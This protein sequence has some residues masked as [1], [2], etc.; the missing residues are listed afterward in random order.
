MKRLLAAALSAML[1]TS[2]LY[3]FAV[4]PDQPVSDE[5]AGVLSEDAGVADEFID[6][7][8]LPSFYQLTGKVTDVA[9]GRIT[10]ESEDGTI[11]LNVNGVTNVADDKTRAPAT[12]DDIDVGDTVKAWTSM[13]ITDSLP[14]QTYA[15]GILI[16]PVDA[17]TAR[18]YQAGSVDV[19]EERGTTVL[20]DTQPSMT[21]T[22][23]EDTEISYAIHESL[24]PGVYYFAWIDGDIAES[25]PEQATANNLV[26]YARTDMSIGAGGI[27]VVEGDMAIP[28]E[29]ITNEWGTVFVPVTKVGQVL[30]FTTRY[31]PSEQRVRL[32]D[33]EGNEVLRVYAGSDEAKINGKTVKLPTEVLFEDGRVY[34]PANLFTEL[35]IMVEIDYADPESDLPESEEICGYPTATTE[36]AWGIQLSALNVTANGMTLVCAQ[37]G[38]EPTGELQT[39]SDY[40]LEK[41]EDGAWVNVK[42]LVQDWGWTSEAWLVK[43]NAET[44][45]E[46]NWSWIYGELPAGTYRLTKKF[47]CFRDAGDYDTKNYTAE[48][49]IAD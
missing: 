46:I 48:F 16:N 19:N 45:W 34:V 7:E 38:G 37:S 44:S 12:L 5:A 27:I 2:P 43:M 14:P 10:V 15:Y 41:E 1:L 30:G 31:L 35:G 11:V 4:E 47:M 6:F 18:F 24:R 40:F 22:V 42:P 29:A 13:A 21:L 33:A 9:D 17:Y 26:V 39:G 49:A 36:D 23:D 20:T 25:F 28:E 3:A 8:G 32:M